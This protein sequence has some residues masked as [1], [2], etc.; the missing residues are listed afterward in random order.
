MKPILFPAEQTSFNTNGL[1]RLTDAISCIVTE[2]ERNGS[3][4]L[5]MEYPID[6]HLMEEI[7][8]SRIICAVPADY[9]AMQ[10]FRIYRISKLSGIVEIDAEHISYQRG[11]GKPQD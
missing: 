10:P 6:G 2:E 7:T 4:E 3:Y 9:K 11:T 5:H 1:G 8:Y